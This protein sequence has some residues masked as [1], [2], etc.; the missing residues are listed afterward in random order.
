MNIL[1]WIF[2]ICKSFKNNKTN[3]QIDR[4]NKLIFSNTVK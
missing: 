4:K 1:V 3:E 2:T